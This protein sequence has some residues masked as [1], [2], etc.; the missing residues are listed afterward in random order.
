MHKTQRERDVLRVMI[1]ASNEK[2]V[3]HYSV[4]CTNKYVYICNLKST[5]SIINTKRSTQTDVNDAH[6]VNVYV[7]VCLTHRC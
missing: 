7:R 5:G 4:D 1:E 2:N 3:T 6:G